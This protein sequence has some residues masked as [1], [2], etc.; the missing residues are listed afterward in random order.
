MA[1]S[2]QMSAPTSDC[3]AQGTYDFIDTAVDALKQG[4]HPFTLVALSRSTK[5]EIIFSLRTGVFCAQDKEVLKDL[6][7]DLARNIEETD[8]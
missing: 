2:A 5:G 8:A 4:G 6:L 3:G 7:P 1:S